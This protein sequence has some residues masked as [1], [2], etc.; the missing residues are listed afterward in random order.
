M[1]KNLFLRPSSFVLRLL[2]IQ[3]DQHAMRALGMNECVLLPFRIRARRLIDQLRAAVFQSLERLGDIVHFKANV[4]D[5]LAAFRQILCQ[6]AIR[7]F[8]LNEFHIRRANWQK[9]HVSAPPLFRL[10]A[11]KFHVQRILKKIERF[12]DACNSNADV[13]NASDHGILSV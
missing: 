7:I 9:R 12:F 11:F 1:T 5:A 2:L 8:R 4:M 3:F 13:I 6:A 10:D